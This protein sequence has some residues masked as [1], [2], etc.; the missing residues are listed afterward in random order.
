LIH[1]DPFDRLLVAQSIGEEIPLISKDPEIQQYAAD[2][3]W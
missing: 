1:R 3:R 2:T